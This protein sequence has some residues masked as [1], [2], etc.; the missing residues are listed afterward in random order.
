MFI[1]VN[2]FA[3]TYTLRLSNAYTKH[4]SLSYNTTHNQD[5]GRGLSGLVP[6]NNFRC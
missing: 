3:S 1:F 4:Q 2:L 6:V 5:E